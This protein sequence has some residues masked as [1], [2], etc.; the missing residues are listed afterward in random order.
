MTS[1]QIPRFHRAAAAP[2]VSLLLALTGSA[3]AAGVS[4]PIIPDTPAS[5]LP[6]TSVRL[7]P[8]SPFTIAV[9]ANLD[10]LLALE[11]D[12]LL[13]P[14]RREA[15]LPAKAKS[16][17]NWETSGLDGHTAGHYLSALSHMIASGDDTPDHQ[18]RQRLDYMLGELQACQK[19]FGDGYVGGVPGSRELWKQ[20][21]AGDVDAVNRKWVPWY[22]LHK[23]FAGLRDAWLETGNVTA[24]D[25]LVPFGDWCV[26]L[27]SKLNDEQM[28]HMLN[29][30]HGGMDEVMA[31]IYAITG[32]R[33]YLT[34]AERF[35]HHAILDP[36]EQHRDELTGLHANTQIPKVIGLE[37]IATLTGDRTA[38]SGARFFWDTVTEHRS[39]AFGGNSV[40]EH[41]NDPHDFQSL[42]M[43]REGPE[44][45][46]TYNMLRLTEGLFA[47]A[48][49]A[50][51]ADYYER[52]LYNHILASIDPTD[53][54]YVY[55]TPI[56]PDH[57]RVYSTPGESFWCCVGTGM[58]NP[59]KYGEFIY[60]RAHD[61]L[62]VNLF[63]ASELKEASLGL[64]LRQETAFP[65]EERSQFTLKLDHPKTFTLYVRQPGWVA[66]SAF[67][68]GVNGTPVAV[69]TAP[70]SY[71]PIRR[72]WHDGDR[73]VIGLP[74]HTTVEGLPDG[75]PWYAI[76]HGPIVLA[77]PAGTWEQTGLRA[78]DARMAHVASG[79]EVPLDQVPV[80]LTDAKTI[81]SKVVPDPAA[82]PMHFRL[83]D[84]VEPPAKDGLTLMP[85]FRLQDQR[86]QMYWETTTRAGIAAQKE[87]IAA[88]ERAR[89]AREAATLDWIT[90][91]EQ[92]PE[93]EH[94][95]KG[96]GTESGLY[97]GR[98]WRHGRDFQYTL[99]TH[100]APAVELSVTYSGSDSGRVFDILA[101]GTL[102]V[103]QKLV[104]EKVGEFVEKRYAI[105]S[106]VLASAPDGRLTIRFVGKKTLA[107]GVFDVRLLRVDGA[108]P[109]GVR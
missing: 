48:P 15:G 93:V 103:T 72:E 8:G 79:P 11:P 13:A 97:N 85:F 44:T 90:P 96:E 88:A 31:D 99:A 100:G 81:P 50:A 98:H 3:F 95:Y 59:G 14:F 41:F 10:Y 43:N 54:G 36:L 34:T 75:S 45:C 40:S 91:G 22:N 55:F 82:G 65:D 26:T 60:A 104:G 20:V 28:Q 89:V 18:L 38:D 27:T 109:G 76:L 39:V 57:Y 52:A 1:L 71:V 4:A 86:Y 6:L 9:K 107:G 12:R 21:A 51:Y 69:A 67:T 87:Q 23:T 63:I 7:I 33:K 49:N 80:L 62:Y 70:S 17:G 46:N 2:L 83:V 29:Q 108:S 106:S 92:Q 77:H 84:V 24:R 19:A 102:I 37:R 58:E 35:E 32:D 42:L 5:I 64:T 53:P 25:I 47:S 56:R 68:L 16:Y 78:D 61:G 66:P 30:E 74:M 101:N 105:P 94:A 73:V